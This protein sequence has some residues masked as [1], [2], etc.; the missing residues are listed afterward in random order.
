MFINSI[1]QACKNPVIFHT[2][3][4]SVH[5]RNDRRAWSGLIAY[6]GNYNQDQTGQ[7]VKTYKLQT[8]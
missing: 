4:N 7:N 1:F 3:Y 5:R 6:H 2:V 8:G